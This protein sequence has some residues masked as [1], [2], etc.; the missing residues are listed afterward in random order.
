MYQYFV[1]SRAPLID[2]PGLATCNDAVEPSEHSTGLLFLNVTYYVVHICVYRVRIFGEIAAIWRQKSQLDMIFLKA[3][4]FLTTQCHFARF[5]PTYDA[6]SA[7]NVIVIG[8]TLNYEIRARVCPFKRFFPACDGPQKMN[9]ESVV[10]C[11]IIYFV[12]LI[13]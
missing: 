6:L 1:D 5:T 10:G 4:R 13:C 11:N 3:S 7:Q 8:P 9:N 12:I 2:A